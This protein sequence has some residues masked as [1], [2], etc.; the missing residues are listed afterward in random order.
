MELI[1][2]G[3]AS[4]L[5]A[6]TLAASGQDIHFSQF[7]NS[8]AN[9][10]PALTGVFG[11]DLRFVANYRSQWQSVPVAYRT[12][13]AAF[14]ARFSHAFLGENS[15]IGYGFFFN[16]DVAGDADLGWSKAG[17][18]LSFLRKLADN[19]LVSLG[20]QIGLG[21]RSVSPQQLTY[22][23]QWNG[24]VFD[25]D[26]PSNE[27]FANTSR[28][29]FDFST[30]LNLHFQ[31]E[32]S[33]TNMDVGLSIAHLNQP[34]TSFYDDDAI[35]LPM[36]T[37]GYWLGVLALNPNFDI[38]ANLI[39]SKQLTYTELVA[40]AAVRY[41]LS[42]VEGKELSA[43]VGMAHRLGDAW[44]PSAELQIRNWT[45][46]FSYDLNNSPFRA[47]TAHRGGPEFTLQYILKKV[48]PP[49]EFKSCPI[50]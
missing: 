16:N 1:R 13:S 6:C 11:G 12:A 23:E 25:P 14:D 30:G 22:G 7:N 31:A 24:D 17:L 44:V 33:R 19:W 5:L 45:M 42:A 9:L 35:V 27:V 10:N 48:K 39:F 29:I 49:K 38:R 28:G 2:L 37:S 26:L 15:Q 4:L 47:A 46:G 41:H 43:Q 50:F 20:T 40:G 18:N 21:Q 3:V 32:D 36:K 34:N 8:P